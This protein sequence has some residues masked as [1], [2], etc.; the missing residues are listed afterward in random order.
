[1]P[2]EFRRVEQCTVGW[3]DFYLRDNRRNGASDAGFAQRI[4]ERLLDH[5]T[6]PTCRR[7][8]ENS[9]RQRL[10]LAARNLV[11][12]EL[13]TNLGSV[14]MNDAKAPAV[15]GQVDD[16]R[17]T[18]SRMAELVGDGRSFSGRRERV[19]SQCDDS[20]PVRLSHVRS[21]PLESRR[22]LRRR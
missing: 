2:D 19:T 11:A 12:D 15:A 5:V 16:R 1:M 8:N 10:D 7:R 3:V 14:A 18:L 17:Q 6:D 21:T 13:I 4:V 9:Q 20:S 22:P